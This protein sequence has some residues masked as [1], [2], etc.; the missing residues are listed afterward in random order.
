MLEQSPSTAAFRSLL[1]WIALSALLLA[2]CRADMATKAWAKGS[3]Q[4]R[5]MTVVPQ[6]LELRYAEN[7]AIAFSMLHNLPDKSRAPLVLGLSSLALAALLSLIWSM[8]RQGVA[9]LVPLALILAGALG[10]L[11]DRLAHGYVVDFVYVHW[12]DRWDFPVFNLADSLITVG[13]VLLLVEFVFRPASDQ[14]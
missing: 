5:P 11:Q 10:N 6:M 3:I 9:R 7:R 4:E 8:R 14:R 12:R 1:R 13:T 2:G